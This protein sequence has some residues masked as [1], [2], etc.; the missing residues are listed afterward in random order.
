MLPSTKGQILAFLKRNGGGTVEDLAA[1]LGVA[2]MTVRQHLAV[3]E[4]DELVASR[5]VRRP[6]GRPHYVYSL[7]ARGHAAFP[8][9]YDHLVQMLLDELAQMEASALLEITGEERVLWVVRRL[10][11]RLADEYASLVASKGL[12]ERVAIATDILQQQGG[13]A[14][15]TK[16]EGGYEI[17]DYNCLYRSLLRSHYA[18]TWHRHFLARL[19]G[20][21]VRHQVDPRCP[22]DCCRYFVRGE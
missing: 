10:A 20:R 2:A 17:R 7:T 21:E 9:R 1:A 15:W 8:K 4:R 13:F 11:D 18:C 6:T 19:L 12:E 22:A 16:V 3:L 14:E 5:A